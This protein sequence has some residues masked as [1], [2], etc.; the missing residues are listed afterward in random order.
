MLHTSLHPEKEG[1]GGC[2]LEKMY[3]IRVLETKKEFICGEN[4][5]VLEAMKRSGIGPVLYG[6]FGGG[7]GV[8]KMKVLS[9]DYEVAQKMSCV[10][11]S[12]HEEHVVL[13]CCI[14]P[15]SDLVITAQI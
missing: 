12:D 11:I 5:R 9:G 6:C 3:R 10:H 15:R 13:I 4:T 7:C 8:C 14:V 1:K 2:L